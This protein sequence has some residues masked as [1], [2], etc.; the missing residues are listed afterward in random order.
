MTGIHRDTIMRLGVRV[1]QDCA[2]F[3]DSTVRGLRPMRVQADEIWTYV[4]KKEGRIRATDNVEILGDQY[5]FVAMD[6][7]SK[8]VI[9]HYIG[10]RDGESTHRFIADL[11]DRIESRI[12]M[13]TDG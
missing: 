6:A 8:L 1:G 9:S 11:S 12:Q 7:D 4:G 10:K 5:V 2:R 13:S 3:L